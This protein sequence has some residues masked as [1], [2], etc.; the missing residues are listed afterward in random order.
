MKFGRELNKRMVDSAQ[1]LANALEG[2]GVNVMYPNRGHTQTN[3]ILVDA[4][5]SGGGKSAMRALA[6]ANILCNQIIIPSDSVS[7]LFDPGGIRIGTSSISR[8]AV[9]LEHLQQIAELCSDAIFERR[10]ALSIKSDVESLAKK[11]STVYY[12]FTNGFPLD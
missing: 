6:N 10:P 7:N 3:H 1:H 4:T 12:N 9:S 5:S 8:K 2:N 11:Y